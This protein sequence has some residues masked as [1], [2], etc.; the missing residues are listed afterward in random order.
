MS[1]SACAAVSLASHCLT[2]EPN[3][4]D[5]DSFSA[6]DWPWYSSAAR[7][8]VTPCVSSCPMTS[9]AI[10][11]RLKIVPSP[12]PKIICDPSQNALS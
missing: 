11:K 10:V 7:W 3:T 2:I 4:S 12:S 9:T 8:S 1:Q 6:P 5:I